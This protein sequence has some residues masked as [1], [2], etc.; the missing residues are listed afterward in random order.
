MSRVVTGEVFGFPQPATDAG[1]QPK[2]NGDVSYE[3]DEMPPHR[4]GDLDAYDEP[5]MK[6]SIHALLL[7]STALNKAL[8]QS[9]ER[10]QE[11]GTARRAMN[12]TMLG[13][14]L[15]LLLGNIFYSVYWGGQKQAEVTAANGAIVRL[16]QR[17]DYMQAQYEA[18]GKQI[19]ELKG[20]LQSMQPQKGR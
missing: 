12:S 5:Q 7:S 10:P 13:G 17:I 1:F 18:T 19:A 15:V 11:N 9:T 14:V 20:M 8:I 3:D 2:P 4:T 6:E 16:E